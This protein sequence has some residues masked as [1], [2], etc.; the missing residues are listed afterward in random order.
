MTEQETKRFMGIKITEKDTL[1]CSVL[2]EQKIANLAYQ[3]ID[4]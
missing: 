4:T 2:A 1:T 3:K